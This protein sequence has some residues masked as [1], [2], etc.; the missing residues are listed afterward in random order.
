MGAP[1]ILGLLAARGVTI[2]P[3]PDGNLEVS[4]RRLLTDETRRLIREHKAELLQVLAADSL[5]DPAAEARRQRV[6]VLLAANPEARYALV[7]DT[8]ADPE[9][10]VVIG[11]TSYDMEMAAN[12]GVPA[13]GVA[14]GYH[15]AEELTQTGAA[16]IIEHYSEAPGAVRRLIGGA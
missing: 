16:V 9:A 12:A 10:T 3:R 14:W 4:P 2:R 8:G 11:D 6:L 7:T 13:I 15:P 1:D 5:P